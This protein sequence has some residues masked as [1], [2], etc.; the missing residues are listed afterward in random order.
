MTRDVCDYRLGID[1]V[2]GSKEKSVLDSGSTPDI[3]TKFQTPIT[4]AAMYVMAILR[5]CI[6]I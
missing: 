2:V 3:S 4:S 1:I 6:W 5:G